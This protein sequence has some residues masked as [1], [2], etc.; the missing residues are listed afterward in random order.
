MYGYMECNIYMWSVY[1]YIYLYD[2]IT[3]NIS[4]RYIIYDMDVIW[5]A[6]P[7]PAPS[8]SARSPA[9]PG[10]GSRHPPAAAETPPGRS[11]AGGFHHLEK[12]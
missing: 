10:T 12:Y 8:G 5:N 1:I 3:Y 7:S 6:S 9:R 4:Y 11:L 2:I